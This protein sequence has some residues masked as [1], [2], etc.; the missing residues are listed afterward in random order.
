MTKPKRKKNRNKNVDLKENAS[1]VEVNNEVP[2]LQADGI[3]SSSQADRYTVD[4]L[5]SRVESYVEQFNFPLALKFSEKALLIDPTST[6]VLEMLGNIY[7]EIGEVESARKYFQQAA[8]LQPEAGHVKFLYLGQL[9]EGLDAVKYYE[10]AIELMRKV[11]E[12]GCDA[13][14]TTVQVSER[15]ISAAY[16]SLAELFM[17][18]LC[19]EENAEAT[20]S[21][22]CE[23]AIESDKDNIDAY[24][25][26][27]NFALNAS[28]LDVSLSCAKQAFTCWQQVT[29]S[30]GDSIAEVVAYQSRL[31]LVKILIEVEDYE[32]V[33]PVI[34]QLI[35]EN[36][37]DVLIWYYMGLSK[38]LQQANNGSSETSELKDASP[39]ESPK[40]FLEKALELFTKTGCEDVDIFEHVKE[41]LADCAEEDHDGMEQVSESS[42][43][44]VVNHDEDIEMV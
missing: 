17:T 31:T 1:T 29:E 28:Q 34:E 26:K 30:V 13:G 44:H 7:A 15:E 6:R 40:Y 14:T 3:A 11:L 36:E 2:I 43:D 16:C 18:D 21:M 37:D 25:T 10:K 12:D 22:Y 20:C 24:I 32:S 39:V 9:S 33:V 38:S 42:A 5:L 41:L 19:T 4:D 8:T 23:A 35:E 27:A